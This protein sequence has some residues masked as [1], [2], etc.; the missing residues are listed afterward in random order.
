MMEGNEYTFNETEDV[1]SYGKLEGPDLKIYIKRLVLILGRDQ[2][3][4]IDPEGEEQFVNLGESQTI[5]RRHAK[6]FWNFKNSSWEIEGLSKNRVFVNGK[7]LKRE[8]PPMT[9]TS[10]SAIRIDKHKFYFFPAVR[11]I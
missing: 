1:E 2:I 9:L 3:K 11:E 4:K 6:I 5:S 7:N 8:E 10:C